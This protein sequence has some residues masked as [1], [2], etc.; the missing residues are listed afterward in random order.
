MPAWSLPCPSS[1]RTLKCVLV[2]FGWSDSQAGPYLHSRV[3]HAKDSTLQH[4]ALPSPL[5]WVVPSREW[6]MAGCWLIP[7]LPQPPFLVLFLSLLL[8]LKP[9]SGFCTPLQQHWSLLGLLTTDRG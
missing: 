1:H 4:V 7:P 3:T 2:E 9:L 5:Q 8:V 6:S